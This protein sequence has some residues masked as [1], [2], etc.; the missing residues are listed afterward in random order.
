MMSSRCRVNQLSRQ[1]Q[2]EPLVLVFGAWSRG[3]ESVA[4]NSSI[5]W[6]RCFG[7]SPCQRL[8]EACAAAPAS[9]ATHRPS[10]FAR[11]AGPRW[12]GVQ[13]TSCQ[14]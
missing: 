14:R 3:A 10:L 5:G 8:F 12:R 11:P 6:N 13:V 4:G 2:Y 1:G 7:G 9:D